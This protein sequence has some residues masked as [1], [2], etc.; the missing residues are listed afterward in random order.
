MRLNPVYFHRFIRFCFVIAITVIS[1]IV[2]FYVST[3]TYPFIIAII[4]AFF[5][6]P[7]VNFFERKARIP[8]WL[9]VLLALLLLFSV[10]AGL[11]TLFIAEI[12]S[13]TIYLSRIL[14]GH[15]ETV[16]YFFEHFF[17]E[18]VLPLYNQ[19]AAL[20]NNLGVQQ[21][22]TIRVNIRSIGE[23]FITE[24]GNFLQKMVQTIPA[25]IAWFPNA[26]TVIIFS[27]LATFFISKD[28]R[29]IS[30]ISNKVI[31]PKVMLSTGHIITDLKGA[32][33]GFIK[34]QVTLITLTSIIVLVGLLVLQV[35]YSITIALLCGLIDI[36]PYLGTGT[37][38]VP[39]IIFEVITGD[40]QLAIGLT[41]LY[42]IVVV[43]RQLIEPKVLSSNIGINPLATLV[44]LFVGYKLIGLLGLIVGPVTLVI[45]DT[46]RRANVFKEVWGFIL[47]NEGPKKI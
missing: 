22:D 40:W 28:W 2:L 46:L 4:I 18:Q 30:M 39:W 38:F 32:L 47:G 7:L 33:I 23:S 1:A 3:Y 43:Q 36:I 45:I 37:V 34:A 19:T 31:P 41:V 29:K 5:M 42:L 8:R 35:N 13:G 6:D 15:L 26:A 10:F 44:A 20:F 24:F 17:A 12:I 27:L 9:S 14:P 21:Q 16:I 11:F 25:I